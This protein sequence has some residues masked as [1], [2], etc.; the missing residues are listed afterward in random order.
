MAS[1]NFKHLHYFWMVARSGSIASASKHLHL[2][3]QSISSQ[4]SELEGRL[5][6][7]LFRRVGR[8][9]ELTETGQRI[10]SYADE[11]F[12]LGDELLALALDQ[13][14][15][16]SLLFRVGIANS[17]PKSVAYRVVEPALRMAEP[18]RLLCREGRLAPLLAEMAVHHLDLVIADQPMPN[19]LN[20]RGYSHFLGESDLTVFAAPQLAQ[21][22]SGDFPALLDRAPFLLPG[23]DVALRP[24]LLRWFETQRLYPHIVGEFE[25]SALLKAFGQAGAGLFVAPTAIADYVTRQY[26]VQAVGRIEAVTERLYAITTERRLLHPA[27]VAVVQATQREFF[28]K[29]ERTEGGGHADRATDKANP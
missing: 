27:I 18:V 11:I 24:D 10:F 14:V 20:V 7:E 16:K 21:S 1:L 4:L 15:R 17:V 6:V 29:P 25:D 9:L 26:T 22:L 23:D 5:G 2:T 3:P 19:H 13:T 28:G 8:G 12:A